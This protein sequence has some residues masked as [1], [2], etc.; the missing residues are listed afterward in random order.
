MKPEGC[1]QKTEVRRQ[2]LEEATPHPEPLY[3]D[4]LLAQ[5]GRE[6]AGLPN[7]TLVAL[8][9]GGL[10]VRLLRSTITLVSVVLAIAF[11]T[12]TGLSGQVYYNVARGSQDLE[13]RMSA[14]PG[15]PSPQIQ[16]QVVHLQRLLRSAGVDVATTLRGDP[17]RAWVVTMALL[18]CAVGIANAMLMSVTERIREIGTMKCLG[19]PDGLVVKLFLLESSFLGVIG[20]ALGMVLGMVVALVAAG[21]Q[22]GSFG[23]AC[24]PIVQAWRVLGGSLLAGVL[25]AVAGAVYPA[26]L[27]ARMT[28]VDAL[29]VDE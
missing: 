7:R 25:L 20:A 12:Y 5:L 6:R 22:F 18:T 1:R 15:A 13:R 26:R 19:A 10:R 24:F 2:K 11:F 16:Q 8:V 17:T 28:P 9:L 14:I 29:R 4:A 27:A 23:F 3:G 21:L